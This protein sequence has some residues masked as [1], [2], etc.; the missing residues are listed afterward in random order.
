MPPVKKKEQKE[1]LMGFQKTKNCRDKKKVKNQIENKK[2]S[3][4]L[5]YLQKKGE[6]AELLS[7]VIEKKQKEIEEKQDDIEKNM[8][9]IKEKQVEVIKTKFLL[10]KETKKR[11]REIKSL[12][13]K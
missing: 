9:S 10:E 4:R 1:V 11:E 13:K 7:A 2:V 5:R 6:K 12:Q 3:D 8:A